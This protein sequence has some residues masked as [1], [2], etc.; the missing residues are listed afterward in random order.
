M[1]VVDARVHAW[2][3]LHRNRRWLLQ[4]LLQCWSTPQALQHASVYSTTR[5]T[6][7]TDSSK[8]SGSAPLSLAIFFLAVNIVLQDLALPLTCGIQ[9]TCV[10]IAVYYA[11]YFRSHS[12][13]VFGLV[14]RCHSR[15]HTLHAVC[16]HTPRCRWAASCLENSASMRDECGF[17]HGG[18]RQYCFSGGVLGGV[19]GEGSAAAREERDKRGAMVGCH[20]VPCM[21]FSPFTAG[22]GQQGVASGVAHAG[23]RT[24]GTEWPFADGLL[25]YRMFQPMYKKQQQ[26][27]EY[28]MLLY[29]CYIY[30]ANST[31]IANSAAG[32]PA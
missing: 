25:S 31:T 10:C 6:C 28:T 3:V 27:D 14:A 4:M 7:A 26:H 24:H 30:W 23:W 20:R 32:V 2:L 5:P 17:G 15:H 11:C 13:C 21:Q 18:K 19:L 8:A 9:N 22:A 16:I 29:T 1:S 12:C